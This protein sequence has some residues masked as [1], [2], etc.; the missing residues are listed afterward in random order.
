[1][2]DIPNLFRYEV[3]DILK[4]AQ[5]KYKEDYLKACR[6]FD[7]MDS[8]SFDVYEKHM[9][10]RQAKIVDDCFKKLQRVTEAIECM[11]E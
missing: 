4:I 8:H 7:V 10:E 9:A 11:C 3:L 5:A 1:M 6:D 2:D